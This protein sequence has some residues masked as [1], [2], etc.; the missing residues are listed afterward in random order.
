M[1]NLASAKNS[2][3]EESAVSNN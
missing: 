1:K 3:L 2:K